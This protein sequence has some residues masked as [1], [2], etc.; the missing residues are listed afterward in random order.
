MAKN[1]LVLSNVFDIINEQKKEYETEHFK[2]MDLIVEDLTLSDGNKEVIS[3]ILTLR[4]TLKALFEYA[5]QQKTEE[6]IERVS[7]TIDQLVLANMQLR[8]YN[9]LFNDNQ[10]AVTDIC[11]RLCWLANISVMLNFEM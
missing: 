7:E 6:L 9:N 2:T 1:E 10:L 8:A 5:K 11:Q 4:K 3:T